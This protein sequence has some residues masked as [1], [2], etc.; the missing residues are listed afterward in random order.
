MSYRC[1][2][3]DHEI[4]PY[5]MH[6]VTLNIMDDERDEFLCD[7]CYQEWLEGLKG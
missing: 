7:E 3:C 5:E 6:M 2:Y 1:F 4:D